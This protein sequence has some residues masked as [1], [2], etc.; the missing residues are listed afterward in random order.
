M[1]DNAFFAT[2]IGGLAAFFLLLVG[3]S[4]GNET[5]MVLACVN[6]GMEW[7]DGDCVR[8]DGE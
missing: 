3:V 6:A 5:K 7:I 8:G 2:M 4:E 1:S